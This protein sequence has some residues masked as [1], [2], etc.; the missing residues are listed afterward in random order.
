[1]HYWLISRKIIADSVET[2][3]SAEQLDGAVL[4]ARCDKS[5]P[6]MAAARLDVASGFLYAGSTLPGQ[7]DGE[8]VTIIDAFEGVGEQRN[9]ADG[10]PGG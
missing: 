10:L 2:V 7:L 1:M 3:F 5:E 4:L 8:T 9:T 6:G